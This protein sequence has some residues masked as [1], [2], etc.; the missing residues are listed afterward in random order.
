MIPRPFYDMMVDRNRYSKFLSGGNTAYGAA[1][2]PQLNTFKP[3]KPTVRAG[4]DGLSVP[5]FPGQPDLPD[6]LSL[7]PF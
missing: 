6:R 3:F 2:I 4:V 7:C 1:P 5:V